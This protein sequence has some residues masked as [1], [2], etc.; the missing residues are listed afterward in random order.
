MTVSPKDTAI[1]WLYMV[2]FV[3]FFFLG[4]FMTMHCLYWELKVTER[5]IFYKRF[6]QASQNI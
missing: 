6:I 5:K 3:F 1:R 4:I 2:V